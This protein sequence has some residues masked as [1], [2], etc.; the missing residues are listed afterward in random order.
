MTP[1]S[2]CNRRQASRRAAEEAVRLELVRIVPN[3]WRC[4]SRQTYPPGGGARPA[5]HVGAS[6][7]EPLSSLFAIE[8]IIMG[9]K[10]ALARPRE[11]KVHR[12]VCVAQLKKHCPEH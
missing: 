7:V 12:R 11:S 2:P 6:I 3:W 5:V 10:R 4:A 1:T 9:G 8:P